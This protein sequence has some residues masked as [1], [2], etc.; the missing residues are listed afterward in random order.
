MMGLQVK[1]IEHLAMASE[2][3]IK[4]IASFS[5]VSGVKYSQVRKYWNGGSVSTIHVED[6]D[7]IA[8]T[9]GMRAIDLLEQV[10][11]EK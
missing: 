4:S 7:K 3:H 6:L 5:K 8:K 1:R 10:D 11:D 2:K 9:L